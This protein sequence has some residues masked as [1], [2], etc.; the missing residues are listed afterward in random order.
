MSSIAPGT[1]AWQPDA[2]WLRTLRRRMAAWFAKAARD[3][4][5]RRTRDPYA[6]W[7]SEVMLQQTQVATVIPY[8]ERFTKAM[9]CIA[10]L[11]AAAEDDVLR[12][13]EGLGYYRRARQL[14]HAA[15]VIVQR[16]GGSFPTE[17]ES[18]RRLPGIGRYTAGAILSIAFDQRLPI[19]EAN[20][21]RLGS[22]LLALQEPPASAAGQRVL[23]QFAELVLPRRGAG[24]M[25]QA[26]ME[27][28]ATVCLPRAPS[29]RTCPAAALC[30][31]NQ[32][33][34]QE[35]I[36][37][38]RPRP[39]PIS[40]REAAIVVWRRGKVAILRQPEGGRWAGLWDFPRFAIHA[41][42]DG[43]LVRELVESCRQLSGLCVDPGERLLVI[44]HGVTR[45]RIELQCYDAKLVGT[46][47]R[48]ADLRWVSPQDLDAYPLNTTGRKLARHICRV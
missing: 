6:I 2:V 24:R 38:P 39:A 13:W 36:P 45:Y 12:L 27:L 40:V 33:G 48:R 34:M 7:L 25:N 11:A 10:A 16:H 3:L 46:S 26:L 20:T 30:R 17:F 42:H 1:D 15:Q 14:H 9:P 35:V 37:P 23:W 21:L 8:F 18:V 44:R 32:L 28:G 29:C 5:W 41:E 43:R 31:A 22:R 47:P 4:P 19:L